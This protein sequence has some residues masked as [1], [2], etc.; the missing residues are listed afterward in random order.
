MTDSVAAS[1]GLA[2]G[3]FWLVMGVALFA[4]F[5]KGTVGFGM[6]MVLISGLGA[7]LPA[8][9]ALAA[10]ILPTVATNIVQ[11]LRG[12][13][14]PA[15]AATRAH[16]RFIVLVMGGIALSAQ[17]VPVIPRGVMSALIGGLIVLF[18]L[19]QLAGWSL[20][21]RRDNRR[22]A[23]LILGA[24]AGFTGGISG[25]W[26]PP[27]VAYLLALDTPKREMVRAQGVVYFLGAVMLTAGHIESGV[28]SA[29][30]APLSAFLLIP[31]LVGLTL[32]F[33]LHDR[34]DQARFRQAT[35]AVLVLAGLNLLRRAAMG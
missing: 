18:A 4:G 30:T 22:R 28:L 24:I 20:R 3:V 34:M 6:P 12:G 29:T 1:I 21:I 2:P 14:R 9:T 7:T 10:L 25:V 13:V 26:G 11:T 19:S 16:W 33:A 35:L 23:E 5:V 15:W 8:E 32:G 27:T 17:L 31:A